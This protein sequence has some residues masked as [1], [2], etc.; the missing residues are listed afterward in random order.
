MDQK[1]LP[2]ELPVQARASFIQRPGQ[3]AEHR[4][5]MILWNI[6]DPVRV[7]LKQNPPGHL[8]PSYHGPSPTQRGQTY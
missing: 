6:L 5:R 3:A 7:L 8:L 2:L 4:L 1:F